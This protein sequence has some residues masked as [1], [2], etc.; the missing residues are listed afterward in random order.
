MGLAFGGSAAMGALLFLTFRQS[1]IGVL[2]VVAPIRAMLTA[3]LHCYF[4]NQATHHA[5]RDA[6]AQ[7]AEREAES[8]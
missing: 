8:A 2:M 7:A 4:R 3:T 5:V 1:G 6:G